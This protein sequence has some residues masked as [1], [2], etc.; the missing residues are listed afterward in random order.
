MPIFVT[1]Q[2][3]LDRTRQID[4]LA[5]LALRLYLFPVFWMAGSNKF[6]SFESTAAWFGNPEWGLGM[7]FP[8]VMAFMATSAELVGAI[9]LLF[10]F[11]VRWATLPLMVTMIVAALTAHIHNGWQAVVDAK[12]CLFNC[13]GIEEATQ[14]LDAARSLLEEHGNYQWLTESGSFVISNNG[15]EWAVTYFIMLLT[16]FFIGSGKYAS[17]DYWLA[18][19]FMPAAA[20]N[21]NI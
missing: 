8:T 4:F 12:M 20:A 11:A 17:V 15:I 19:R 18:K 13:Q 6:N 3:L 1:L 7:P 21:Q 14:R 16:L 10:G 5:P 2:A 9:C